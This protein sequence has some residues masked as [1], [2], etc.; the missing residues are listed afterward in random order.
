MLSTTWLSMATSF[1][2]RWS[3]QVPLICEAQGDRSCQLLRKKHP[4][5]QITKPHPQGWPTVVDAIW[6]LVCT[7]INVLVMWINMCVQIYVYTCIYRY[8]HCISCRVI[9]TAHFAISK[10]NCL[11][12]N[13]FF[14]CTSLYRIYL[15]IQNM[16]RITRLTCIAVL[17]D[18]VW[19]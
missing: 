5:P 15:S 16:C 13:M 2:S 18:Q 3:S 12:G 19:W 11:Q 17:H 7:H 14:V 8:T 9:L 4:M 10:D 1:N 6:Y